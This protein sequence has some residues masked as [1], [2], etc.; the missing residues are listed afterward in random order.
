MSVKVERIGRL[1]SLQGFELSERKAQLLTIVVMS[2]DKMQLAMVLV[3]LPS[4]KFFSRFRRKLV[5][6]DHSSY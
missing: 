2:D 5:A 1:Q 6:K 4:E 3:T